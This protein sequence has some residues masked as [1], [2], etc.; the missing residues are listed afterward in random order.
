MLEGISYMIGAEVPGVF[1]NVMRGGP[2]LGNIAPEQ[3]DIKLAC[4]GLG[5]GN[6][7]AIVSRPATPQEMLD[8]THAG[9]RARL[10]VPQ[11]G[12]HPRRR[13][14][15]PDDRQ[16]RCPTTMVKPGIPAWA[17]CGDRDAPRQP[18]LA[19]ST[20]PRPTSRQHNVAPEREVRSR[21]KRRAARRPLPAATT[22]RSSSSPA[23]RRRAWPRAPSRSC[24]TRASRRASSARSRSG[25]FPIDAAASRC[26]RSA[27]RI[28][29]VEASNGQLEDELRLALS[30]RRRPQPPADRPRAPLW[31]A[32]CRSRARSSSTGRRGPKEVP[33]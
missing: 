27:K 33:A 2:G 5:H 3:A 9:L 30:Q 14:S 4:R 24:A 26:C 17:V 18:D 23:T 21:C 15:R 29:V 19:R 32:C 25:R 11:P 13:L 7:H 10:Q 6:T 31:A 16:G 1:V 22:P 12:G 8:L 20:S 28:V